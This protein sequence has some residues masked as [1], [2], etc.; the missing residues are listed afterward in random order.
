MEKV[1]LKSDNTEWWYFGTDEGLAVIA[2][3]THAP[4]ITVP[5]DEIEFISQP[6]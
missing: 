6:K 5:L 1:I 2:K 4:T 3:E